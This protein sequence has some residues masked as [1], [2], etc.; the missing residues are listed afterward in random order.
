[1]ILTIDKKIHHL[2]ELDFIERELYGIFSPD[3][4]YADLR[5]YLRTNPDIDL[6]NKEYLTEFEVRSIDDYVKNYFFSRIPEAKTWYMRAYII[7]RFLAE[8][9]T[10]GTVVSISPLAA[11]PEFVQT[12][13]KTYGLTLQEAKM[14]ESALNTTGMH[15]TNTTQGT[16]Q[17]V[18]S[19][20][21][22]ALI[23]R[24]GSPG[25][26]RRLNEMLTSDI[27]ELNRNWKRVAI[28]ETNK[29]FNDGY[30]SQIADGDYVIG[31]S[32]PDACG[33]CLT[34]INHK[35]YEVTSTP[36][37]DYTDLDGEERGKAENDWEMKVWAGKNNVGR[38]ASRRSRIDKRGGNNA[39]NLREKH[40]HEKSMPSCPYHPFCRCRFLQFNPKFQWIDEDN[41][42][43]L[44]FED[45]E[46]HQ[47]W[48]KEHIG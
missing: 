7:G 12:A 2:K 15:I 24:E 5:E 22:E 9:D 28:T 10:A 19:A 39:E 48:V 37:P 27:G 18:Q 36:P 45:P 44:S 35:I 17:E 3:D 26:V 43:R 13:A 32:M 8:S 11:M 4:F 16:V 23:R 34:D 31:I 41:N 20:I 42:V 38:T 21:S 1:M 46:K 30:I 14:L 33:H 40:H 25:A 6:D 29:L 47:T